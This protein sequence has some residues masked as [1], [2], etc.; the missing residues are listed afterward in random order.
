MTKKQLDKIKR[1]QIKVPL[2]NNIIDKAGVYYKDYCKALKEVWKEPI[3]NRKNDLE[4]L[5]EYKLGYIKEDYVISCSG[6]RKLHYGFSWDWELK[7]LDKHYRQLL[8]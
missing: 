8:K 1:Y 4:I 6:D 5:A 2:I 3:V 7:E